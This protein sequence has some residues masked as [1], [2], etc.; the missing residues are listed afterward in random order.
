LRPAGQCGVPGHNYHT[1]AFVRGTDQRR[2]ASATRQ[3]IID[4]FHR[5]VAIQ[6]L[7]AGAFY[8]AEEYHQDYAKKNPVRYGM[9]R[10][11]CGRD[12]QLSA[13]WGDEAGKVSAASSTTPIRQAMYTVKPKPSDA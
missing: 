13:I 1:G 11:G 10:A 8:A 6:M 5:E 9:Y 2:P 4:R 3:Q 12:R 7:T